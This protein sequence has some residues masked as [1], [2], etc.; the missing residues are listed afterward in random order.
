MRPPVSW[1]I[2]LSTTGL[3]KANSLAAR[4][5][6]RLPAGVRLYLPALPQDPPDAIENA[7]T[8]LRRENP[9]LVPVPHI[10]AS[11]EP[12][13]A[14][15]EARLAAWQRASADS[16]REAL[17]VRGDSVGAHDTGSAP[18]AAPSAPGAFATS[19]ELLETGALARCGVEAVSLC[20]H[21]EGISTAGLSADTARGALKSKLAWAEANS[22]PARVVTQ[23]CFYTGQATSYVDA[24]RA[25]GVG[26]DV[27]LGVVGPSSLALRQ[28]MAERCGVA[29]P[30]SPY[31]TP[32]MRRIAGWQAG[33]SAEKGIQG[34]HVYPFGGVASTLKWLRDF[35]D[36]P[37]FGVWFGALE[38]PP[39][40]EKDVKAAMA[41][42]KAE[43]IQ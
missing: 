14:S 25:D 17:V 41:T 8:L 15:L 12:S 28:R 10:A 3:L 39:P 11:R 18:T 43:R 16:V 30:T 7:L 1:S 36:D 13:V 26:A 2:E 19:L 34:L 38:P 37:E 32:Y 40:D 31:S 29:A 42:L 6:P 24:L 33:K 23:F 35:A 4:V 21:P 5:L 27:S 9:G 22:V 20:G